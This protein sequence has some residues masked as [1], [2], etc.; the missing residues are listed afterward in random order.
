VLA[1]AVLA[2][3]AAWLAVA[4]REELAAPAA[5]LGAGGCLALGGG[6]AGRRVIL[7][8]PGL[9]LVGGEYAL[10]VAADEDSLDA[11]APLVA[12]G[13][14][15][16]GELA[17]WSTELRAPVVDE[18][19]MWWRR[20]ALVGVEATGAYV[21]AT[22]LLALADSGVRGGLL[23]EVVGV[24]ALAAGALAVVRLAARR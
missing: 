4:V 6:V 23:L 15:A 18:A 13:L 1:I 8:A 11:R 7:V 24:V 5:L 19:G 17:A 10:L 16:A 9:A 12:A 3:V 20:V 2:A 21:V 14:L 22:V